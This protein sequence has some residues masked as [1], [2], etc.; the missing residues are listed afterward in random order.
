M[1]NAAQQAPGPVEQQTWVQCDACE[2]WRRI[3]T[4]LAQNLNDDEPWFCAN[5]PDAAHSTCDA[6]QEL[7]D[8]EIDHLHA[9]T[10]R[11][12]KE[13]KAGGGAA[14]A[15]GGV[16]A[17]GGGDDGLA[18]TPRRHKRPPVWQLITSNM[19]TFRER[20]E[21]DEDDIMICQ[22]KKVWATDHTSVG[23]GPECL[24]RMLNIECVEVR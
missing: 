24:N 6:P 3:P 17:A 7:T 14:A 12:A 13:A 8:A 2:K 16:D 11:A 4:D 20:K 15:Q 10:E 18:S 22:C 23:C 9:E 1:A 5:N 21:Q 19:Y